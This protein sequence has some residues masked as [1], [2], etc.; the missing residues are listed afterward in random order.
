MKFKILISTILLF[1]TTSVMAGIF[2]N[3][4]DSLKGGWSKNLPIDT[5][6]I[7]DVEYTRSPVDE[8]GWHYSLNK[9][10]GKPESS[11]KSTNIK[12]RIYN[13][14]SKVTIDSVYIKIKV[15]ECSGGGVDCTVIDEITVSSYSAIPPKQARYFNKIISY[16]DGGTGNIYFR[17]SINSV[18]AK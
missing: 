1:V 4:K 6:T 8:R 14:S 3:I 5:I 17:H 2:D 13:N 18:K 11:S 7:S 12:G 16:K 10:V 9:Y 15:L